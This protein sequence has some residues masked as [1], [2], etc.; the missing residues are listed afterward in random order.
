MECRN[1]GLGFT[2]PKPGKNTL[3]KLYREYYTEK[4]CEYNEGIYKHVIKEL[5]YCGSGSSNEFISILAEKMIDA[6]TQVCPPLVFGTG[7]ILDV[8]CGFGRLLDLFKLQ[9]WHTFGVEPGIQ[10]S[11]YARRH[12]HKII[13][14]EIADAQF[15]EN[16][17][18]CIVF[19]HSFEHISDPILA[20]TEAGRILMRKGMVIIEVP[21][22]ACADS[23]FYK[24]AWLGWHLPFHLY[25][26]SK[27]SLELA[28]RNAG[29]KPIRWKYKLPT[30]NDIT[31]N[32]VNFMKLYRS[33]PVNYYYTIIKNWVS[34]HLGFNKPNY[35]H[36][37]TLYAKKSNNLRDK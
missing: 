2:D 14:G 25:H 23:V 7:R 36:F 26:W 29:F 9:G 16:Y 12:G 15:P 6:M 35:N 8:G 33:K 31:Y 20:L 21:N 11:K 32:T 30:T 3:E 1:C 10:A 17:F 22:A 19:S 13:T 27:K 34:G 5:L 37:I 18:S 4:P 24:S 28:I